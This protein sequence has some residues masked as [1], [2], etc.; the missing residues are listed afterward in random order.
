MNVSD[1]TLRDLVHG[2]GAHVDPVA[3]VA[4]I[5]AAVAG[6]MLPGTPHT[7]W[8][9]VWHMNYWM[10]YELRSIDGPEVPYP[11]EA[12]A[13]WPQPEPPSPGAWQDEMVRFSRLIARL[14]Q[15]VEDITAGTDSSRL[16]HPSKGETMSD[17]L[18]QMAAHNSYHTGQ[19]VLLRRALGAGSP[20]GGG[21]T[22]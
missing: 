18:W 9:L 3:C 8:Q 10:D 17:V 22:W 14:V 16:V 21:D 20:T 15:W 11:T 19:V 12:A 5:S 6:R 1:R 13:S 7:I 2:T 4:G